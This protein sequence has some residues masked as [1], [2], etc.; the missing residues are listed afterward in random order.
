MR[1]SPVGLREIADPHNL[2]AAFHAA[3]AGKRGR[4]DVE[5]FRGR[6]ERELERLRAELT[7][8]TYCPGPMRCF[9]I[10]D[11]KPRLIHAPCFRDRVAHHAIMA[12]AGP[13]LDRALIFDTYACRVGKGTLAA[14]QRASEH[15]ARHAWYGQ[16]DI[17]AYFASIRHDVLLALLARRFKSKAL[18]RLFERIVRSHAHSPGRGPGRGL[19]IGA[20]T[21]QYFANFYLSGADRLV[22]E[23]PD[24]GGYVRYMDDLVWWA[25]DRAAVRRVAEVLRGYLCEE[26]GLKMKPPLHVGQSVHGLTFCGF[27]ILPRRLLLSRRRRIRYGRLRRRAESDW[28]RGMSGA[29]GL[30]SAYSGALALTLHADAKAWRRLQLRRHPVAPALDAL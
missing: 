13:V 17:R 20:L 5:A 4:A 3:A 12:H 19:P 30:Q 9:R 1:R 10:H 8:E 2:A 21:S 11:P 15:A 26:L 27:R 23:R 6:L 16:T 28:L 24:V 25:D 18:L 14:V 22:L 29:A 7:D